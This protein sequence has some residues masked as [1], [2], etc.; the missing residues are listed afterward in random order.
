MRDA[1]TRPARR[2]TRV[3]LALALVIVLCA[4]GI[5]VAK[6]RLEGP[7]VAR[8]GQSVTVKARGLKPGYYSLIFASR[9][10]SGVVCS[11]RLS[12]RRARRGRVT[13]RGRI[14]AKLPCYRGKRRA[15]F[16]P[17]TTSTGL[18]RFIVC[19]RAKANT[20]KPRR[21]VVK[22]RVAISRR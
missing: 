7:K 17:A 9:G 4:S 6:A 14:P 10:E 5:A 12:A 22:R 21:S 1:L 15:E 2:R 20:C 11:K 16:G 3:A 8:V 18:Y 13:L 19:V